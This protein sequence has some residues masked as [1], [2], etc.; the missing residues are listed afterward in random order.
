M[1]LVAK[2]KQTIDIVDNILWP[3]YTFAIIIKKERITPRA[4]P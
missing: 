3:E 1:K 2:T 4:Y